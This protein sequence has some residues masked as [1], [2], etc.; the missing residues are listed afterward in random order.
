MDRHLCRHPYR[1]YFQYTGATLPFDVYV[2]N[3][4]GAAARLASFQRTF[5][6][7]APAGS[8]RAGGPLVGALHPGCRPMAAPARARTRARLCRAVRRKLPLHRAARQSCVPPFFPRRPA[9]L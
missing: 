6:V 1:R 7:C 9:G 4:D 5:Q 3:M 2:I 8:Q